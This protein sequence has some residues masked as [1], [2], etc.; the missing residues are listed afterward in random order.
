MGQPPSGFGNHI[1]ALV[2][3]K[4][5]LLINKGVWESFTKIQYLT[6]GCGVALG[7]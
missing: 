2:A 6:N 5:R 7:L 3:A 4:S 1:A